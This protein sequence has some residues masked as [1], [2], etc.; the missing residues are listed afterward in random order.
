MSVTQK[1]ML[2]VWAVV[3][4]FT[5][6]Q[7]EEK[8]VDS[9]PQNSGKPLPQLTINAH[10]AKI[11]PVISIPES[12]PGFEKMQMIELENVEMKRKDGSI[13]SGS[14][15][16]VKFFKADQ[17]A[18]TTLSVEEELFLSSKVT[19]IAGTTQE[20]ITDRRLFPSPS[21]ICLAHSAQVY[22]DVYEY[23][24]RHRN[25]LCDFCA[26][27]KARD[28]Y[29]DCMSGKRRSSSFYY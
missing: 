7:K 17:V 21:V 15:K 25:L 12:H 3:L 1:L 24:E 11:H 18:L 28:A 29:I 20:L 22:E 13:V 6:C 19:I 4:F 14:G 23:N 16:L 27:G 26:Y 9:T 8:V 10:Q 2:T 5:A